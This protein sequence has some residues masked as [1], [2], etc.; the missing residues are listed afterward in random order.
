MYHLTLLHHCLLTW[1]PQWQSIH[2]T[3]S[4][5]AFP[6]CVGVSVIVCG[7]PSG[8]C[9]KSV[10]VLPDESTVCKDDGRREDA[11]GKTAGELTG[12]LAVGELMFG[13][14]LKILSGGE[15]T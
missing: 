15:L 12:R 11:A 5:S 13:S 9:T 1:E 10:T 4:C 6:T 3:L 8:L 2:L 14:C 7:I